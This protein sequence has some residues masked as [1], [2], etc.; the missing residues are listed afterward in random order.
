MPR[1]SLKALN[2]SCFFKSSNLWNK[3]CSNRL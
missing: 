2:N 1:I 3:F